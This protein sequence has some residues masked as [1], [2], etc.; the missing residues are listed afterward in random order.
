LLD[1]K[2][3]FVVHCAAHVGGI[4]Y[5][6][7]RPVEIYEDNVKIGLNIVKACSRARVRGLI[8]VM[9]NCTY[10]GALTL[11][12]E[13]QWWDGPM[14]E[15]VLTYGLPRK[16]MWGLA[17]AYHSR[18][19]LDS[20]HLVLPNMYGPGDHFDPVRSHALGALISKIV[21]AK[22]TNKDT[23][24][25]WGTGKPVR[26]W[27]YVADGAKAIEL[28]I[29]KFD[30]I[31]IDIMNVG[32]GHGVSITDTANMI[33]EVVGWPGQFVYRPEKPDGAM[34][35]ILSP[36][37]MRKVLQWDPATGLAEG[38]KRTVEW[39]MNERPRVIGKSN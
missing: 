16:A 37:K 18:G 39:Y 28:A 29:S 17:W 36:D 7:Q 24:E 10:P 38:I 33:K 19:L 1:A 26:E 23:V 32:A 31:G 11:Y 8:N 35:K 21:E 5:N 12:R 9:P 25:I 6:E 3:E 20:A 2:P 22:T 15:T 13:D 30:R 34:I 14:H 27:L 4:A